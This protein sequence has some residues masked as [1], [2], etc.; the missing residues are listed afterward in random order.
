MRWLVVCLFLVL[1]GCSTVEPENRGRLE[2]GEKKNMLSIGQIGN[3]VD[4]K[5]RLEEICGERFR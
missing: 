2:V 4:E 1:I 5:I 3:C